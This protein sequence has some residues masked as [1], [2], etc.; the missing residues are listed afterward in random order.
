MDVDF[1]REKM[2]VFHEAWSYLRDNYYDPAYHGANWEQVRAEYEPRI[3]GARTPDEVRRLLQLMIGE[4]NGSHLG[5]SAPPTQ[6]KP[7][8][9][10]PGFALNRAEKGRTAR[11]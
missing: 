1:A 10:R 6:N 2:E 9:A 4:L 5:A 7:K 8:Q 11:W 3:A